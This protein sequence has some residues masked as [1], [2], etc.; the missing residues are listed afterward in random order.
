MAKFIL[1]DQ[2]IK[3]QGGHYLEY[4]QH[5]LAAARRQGY[6]P[7]IATNEEF[8]GDISC[9]CFSVYKYDIWGDN[10]FTIKL[11]KKI[12]PA[13]NKLGG[14]KWALK[15]KISVMLAMMQFSD[16]GY[17]KEAAR[18]RKFGLV[19]EH[20]S[21]IKLAAFFIAI[22]LMSPF[23][24]LRK[25][26][27]R[28]AAFC[29]CIGGYFG[30][31]FI[32]ANK[33]IHKKLW[34]RSFEKCTGKVIKH[35]NAAEGDLVFI[36]T[37]SNVDLGGLKRLVKRDRNAQAVSWHLIFRRNLLI[38]REPQYWKYEKDKN[39]LREITYDCALKDVYKRMYF[40]TDTEKLTQ[41]Y[42]LMNTVGFNTLPIPV[43]PSLY[44]LVRHDEKDPINIVYLGDA[45]R[46]KGYQEL[47]KIVDA[48]W[49]EY[50]IKNK[51]RFELQS[52]FSFT[53][54]DANI[55]I[56]KARDYLEDLPGRHV[57][58]HK[59]PLSSEDYLKL[60]KAGDIALLFYDRDNY[61]ARSSG[62]LVECIVAGI[63]VM[64]PSGSWLSEQICYDN[65]RHMRKV[66][67]ETKILKKLRM[68]DVEWKN[69]V[70]SINPLRE[71]YLSFGNNENATYAVISKPRKANALFIGYNVNSLLQAGNFIKTKIITKKESVIMDYFESDDYSTQLKAEKV[72]LGWNINSEA[73][74]IEIRFSNAFG[75]SAVSITDFEISFG[76]AGEEIRLGSYGLIY[77]GFDEVP[78]LMTN[79]IRYFPEYKLDAENKAKKYK[80]LHN[81]ERLV[82]QLSEQAKAGEI[83]CQ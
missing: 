8:N 21:T 80:E 66:K 67:E 17:F 49:E 23:V 73:D 30:K 51:V 60:V 41:Q 82:G 9:P 77:S 45:R 44:E 26:L 35:F 40:Y 10:N 5:V 76:C 22:V 52:N 28:P 7:C 53:N 75:E 54:M 69:K 37:L 33:L 46:E 47:P 13:K 4:A 64:V 57:T 32:L 71:A 34:Q 39:D 74:R 29:R 27:R 78:L 19:F 65:Y 31:A 14:S 18:E 72:Y 3:G 50:A 55:D 81:A 20:I 25:I 62:A 42:H 11:K 58:L 15:N 83:I 2:S 56:V 61:Y 79:M 38:G 48:L 59:S 24:L 68:E 70:P 43:N 12:W 36:P 1:I 63:P 16:I 6:E